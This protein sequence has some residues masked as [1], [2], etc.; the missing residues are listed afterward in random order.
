MTACLASLATLLLLVAQYRVVAIRIEHEEVGSALAAWFRDAAK[1]NLN[2]TSLDISEAANSTVSSSIFRFQT[3]SLTFSD[4]YRDSEAATLRHRYDGIHLDYQ[5]P[6]LAYKFEVTGSG[7]KDTYPFSIC[8]PCSRTFIAK[9]RRERANNAELK[10]VGI[11]GRNSQCGFHETE[12]TPLF[13][14]HRRTASYTICSELDEYRANI[15]TSAIKIADLMHIIDP[16]V[17]QHVEK[18]LMN[19]D[20]KIVLQAVSDFFKFHGMNIRS[21]D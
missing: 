19:A 6:T 7:D 17:Q 21:Y 1:D 16:F 2:V 18:M 20:T 15:I 8:S 14:V 10:V 13:M 9:L 3:L 4:Q 5:L 12:I 11:R